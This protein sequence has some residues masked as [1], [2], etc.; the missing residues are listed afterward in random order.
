MNMDRLV[1]DLRTH[2]G[3]SDFP[4]KDSLGILTIGYGRNLTAVG[5]SETEATVMLENDI[6]TAIRAAKIV[7]S[8]F[9]ELSDRRQEVLVNMAFNM[10][11][12]K[13]SRFKKT[14][15]YIEA[16]RFV[17]ASHEMLD[18]LWAQQVHGRAIDLSK[19]MR[20]G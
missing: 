6:H 11:Q 10:G 8:C 18:S 13:L 2:E 9:A 15:E 4:Y 12:F 1:A 5:I 3:F 14:L 17:D 19:W 20:E 7:C 16:E